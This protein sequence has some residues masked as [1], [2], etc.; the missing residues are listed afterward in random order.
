MTL[1]VE[2]MMDKMKSFC[3]EAG[4][5]CFQIDAVIGGGVGPAAPQFVFDLKA[6]NS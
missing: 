4:A 5:K 2:A 6:V 3:W 1:V